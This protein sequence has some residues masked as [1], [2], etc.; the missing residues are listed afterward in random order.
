MTGL[1]RFPP[2]PPIP[3]APRF[4]PDDRQQAFNNLADA[5]GGQL[6]THGRVGI[7]NVVTG[8]PASAVDLDQLQNVLA[9]AIALFD[10]AQ[11]RE[12]W[13][14]D[15]FSWIR[16][17]IRAWVQRCKQMHFDLAENGIRITLETQDD[18][19][20]NHYEFDV[21]PGRR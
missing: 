18:H 19:G 2:L 15:L 16:H 6:S 14:V 4:A 13:S 5:I 21:F 7:A 20:Y 3:D 8:F 12:R 17:T 9:E 11:V 10:M 1:A